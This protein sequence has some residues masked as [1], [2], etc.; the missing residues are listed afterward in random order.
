MNEKKDNIILKGDKKL[1]KVSKFLVVLLFSTNL[2]PAISLGA[3]AVVNEVNYTTVEQEEIGGSTEETDE[4]ETESTTETE[5]I[6]PEIPVEEKPGEEEKPTE[7]P[8]ETPDSSSNLEVVEQSKPNQGKETPISD[9]VTETVTDENNDKAEEVG[10]PVEI[11]NFSFVPT[12]TEK[13]FILKIGNIARKIANENDLYASVMIAQA[14]LESGFGNSGLANAPHYNLFGIKGSNGGKSVSMSTQEEV[15]G[16]M[17]TINS[18]FRSYDSYEDSIK[19]YVELVDKGISS[20][21]AI[22]HG[23]KKVNAATY[24]DATSKLVGVY[25]TDSQY[26]QKLDA[27]IAAYD[28]TRFDQMPIQIIDHLLLESE[29]IESIL[30]KY[31]V[32]LTDLS[33]QGN[34]VNEETVISV[35]ELMTIRKPAKF[36]LPLSHPYQ[37]SSQFGTRGSEDHAGI[38]LAVTANT[39]VYA[40]QAGEIIAAGFDGSAGNY[41]IIKHD[42]GLYSN[43]FHLNE[44]NVA[45]GNKVEVKQ[46]IGLV[47]STGNSTGPHLHFGI[48]DALWKSYYNPNDFLTFD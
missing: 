37:V 42:F 6:D 27:I 43:Y 12:T 4:P 21:P 28:L 33:Y 39:P 31:E 41:V 19:D 29:S 20:N 46:Q 2:L 34:P 1:R 38:D 24:Q 14:S 35:G 16:K 25:A 17:I 13:E 48:S 8:E 15:T 26:N 30:A 45:V 32:T 18:A 44:T 47:G 22:Y 11:G 10:T 40:A 23:I 5:V 3:E 7:V 36:E 9:K